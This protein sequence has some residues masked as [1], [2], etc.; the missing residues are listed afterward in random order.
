MAGAT[1][2]D[3]IT[4]DLTLPGLDDFETCRRFRGEGVQTSILMLTASDAVDVRVAGLDTGADDYLTG[5]FDFGELLARLRALA[6]RG[7]TSG[8]RCCALGISIW[9]R[10][11]GV[12]AAATPRSPCRRRSSICWRCSCATPASCSRATGRSREP[13]TAHTST[14]RT[15]STSTC[16]TC[17]RRSIDR[18]APRPSIRGAGYRLTAP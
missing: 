16:A 11:R 4:L 10:R 1:P 6:R 18:L 8:S 2:Y 3:V 12:P 13:G 15:S 14:A 17:A 9:T 5:P 7:P